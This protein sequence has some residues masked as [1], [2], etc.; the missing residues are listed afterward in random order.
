M[1]L[2]DTHCHLDFDRYQ[3]DL[4]QVLKRAW[5]AG[6]ERIIIPAIE[7]E[8]SQQVLDIAARTAG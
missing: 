4:D 2:V 7:L 8:S 3:E 6:V 5:E 1:R